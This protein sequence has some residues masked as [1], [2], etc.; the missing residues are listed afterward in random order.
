MVEINQVILG[1]PI[2]GDHFLWSLRT[3]PRPQARDVTPFSPE[4]DATRRIP[5]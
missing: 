5:R 2:D 4:G 1:H 3:L